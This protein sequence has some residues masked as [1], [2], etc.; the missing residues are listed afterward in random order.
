MGLTAL[1]FASSSHAERVYQTRQ[2]QRD[3]SSYM[4]VFDEARERQV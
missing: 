4:L 2:G 3:A 1:P